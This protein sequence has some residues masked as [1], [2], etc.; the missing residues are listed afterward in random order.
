MT[1]QVEQAETFPYV[2]VPNGVLM[3]PSP[4]HRLRVVE[5]PVA[6]PIKLELLDRGIPAPR[7]L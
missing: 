1:S 2:M 3:K 7:S 5:V 6:E 4:G